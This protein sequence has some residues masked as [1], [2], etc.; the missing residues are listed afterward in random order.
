MEIVI[1]Y[2]IPILIIICISGS[3]IG[4]VYYEIDIIK[5]ILKNRNKR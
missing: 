3:I 2:L 4:I 1:S 5:N